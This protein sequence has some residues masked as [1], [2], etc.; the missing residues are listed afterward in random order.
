MIGT[1]L[2]VLACTLKPDDS[3]PSDDWDS[4]ERTVWEVVSVTDN[5]GGAGI[6]PWDVIEDCDGAYG[7]GCVTCFELDPYV[8]R[9]HTW[10]DDGDV[11]EST[12]AAYNVLGGTLRYEVY[13]APGDTGLVSNPD[14]DGASGTLWVLEL[15]AGEYNTR[16]VR[17]LADGDTTD[18][19][20]QMVVHQGCSIEG[21]E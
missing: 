10:T 21:V 14:L 13:A 17:F 11:T 18:A 19:A 2:L 12:D 7:E 5:V 1:L 16:T 15:E 20:D 3:G 6:H 8:N 9:I 4:F